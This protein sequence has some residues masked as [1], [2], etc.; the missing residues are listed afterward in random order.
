MLLDSKGTKTALRY[1][2]CGYGDL[3]ARR[4][5]DTYI[6][7]RGCGHKLCPR[8]SRKR[9]SK[10]ARRILGWVAREAHGDLFAIC[11]TQRVVKG[12]A[13]A[14][15]RARI[16]KKV[17]AF[18]RHTSAAGMTAAMTTGHIVW[19]VN[20]EGWHVHTHVLAEFPAG[21]MSRLRL[22]WEW[23][24]VA[25]DSR[26][27]FFTELQCRR[28]AVAGPPIAEL[29]ADAG[30][31]DFWNEAS[32]QVARAV[33]YPVRD[34]AQSVNAVRLGGGGEALAASARELVRET[35]GWKMFRAWGRWK[36]PAPSKPAEK[37]D[38]PG[39][40]EDAASAGVVRHLGTVR[41]LHRA[42]RRGD[43]GARAVFQALE[44]T[45]RNVS[46]FAARFVK[47]CRWAWCPADTT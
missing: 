35:H 44:S 25:L 43:P 23:A 24:R 8:C 22:L 5:T 26:V 15:A 4:G 36:G 32:S 27:D 2:M 6:A 19:S 18:M 28:V 7:P 20:G 45:V 13:L 34:M 21:E 12:E 41:G 39:D 3:V 38:E 9:G 14:A 10:Y 1:A 46:D 16:E 17:R 31:I 29:D 37:D 47:F 11:L 30:D 40:G 33:Q 42:A